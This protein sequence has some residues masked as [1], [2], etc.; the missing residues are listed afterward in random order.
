VVRF[1]TRYRFFAAPKWCAKIDNLGQA[2]KVMLA[3]P[4]LSE[5]NLFSFRGSIHEIFPTANMCG[6]I[7]YKRRF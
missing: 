3:Q 1:L 6:V 4:L 2:G 7:D 5:I